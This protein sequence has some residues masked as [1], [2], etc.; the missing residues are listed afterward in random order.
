MYVCGVYI[1]GYNITQK[2]FFYIGCGVY[3][4]GFNITQKYFFYIKKIFNYS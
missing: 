2:Y 1:C 3:I 4:C